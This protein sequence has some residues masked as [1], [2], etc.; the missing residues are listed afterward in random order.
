MTKVIFLDIDG[1]LNTHKTCSLPPNFEPETRFETHLMVHS[2]SLVNKLSK[3]NSAKIVVSSTWRTLDKKFHTN[4]WDDPELKKF[5]LRKFL[6]KSGLVDNFH[7]D[8]HTPL[9]ERFGERINGRPRGFE[10]RDWLENHSEITNWVALDDWDW[11]FEGDLIKHLSKTDPNRGLQDRD[12]ELAN[13]I[14]VG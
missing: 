12:Y 6:I 9:S 4:E 2:I 1:V 10:I 14:L 5:D 13:K 11:G 3:D 8:W 7:E